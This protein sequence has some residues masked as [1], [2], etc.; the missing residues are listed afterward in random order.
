[1]IP[2]VHW[3]LLGIL[4]EWH[5]YAEPG[6]R[7]R[8]PFSPNVLFVF[9]VVVVWGSLLAAWLILSLH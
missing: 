3:N 7:P 4:D 1:M 8:P 5:N 2:A 6:R 9:S